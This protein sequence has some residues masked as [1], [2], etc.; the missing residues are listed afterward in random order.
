MA[1]SL[2][3]GST[4][5]SRAQDLPGVTTG[6]EDAPV[7]TSDDGDIDDG[8]SG[9]LTDPVADG[10]STLEAPGQAAEGMLPSTLDAEKAESG[11]K[12]ED[13]KAVG[14]GRRWAL[15]KAPQFSSRPAR[16]VVSTA[17]WHP[18]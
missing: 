1:T 15:S 3:L 12:A 4:A 10:T 14:H 9:R 2:S 8:K 17:D 7:A 16:G 13:G 18:R 11:D 5:T 6:G